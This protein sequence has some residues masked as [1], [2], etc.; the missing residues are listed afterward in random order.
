MDSVIEGEKNLGL[1]KKAL[2]SHMVNLSRKSLSATD[3][4]VKDKWDPEL[5]ETNRML[6]AVEF[7]LQQYKGDE[8]PHSTSLMGTPGRTTTDFFK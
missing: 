5:D 3:K 8:P 4:E 7:N 6:D 2:E 1:L